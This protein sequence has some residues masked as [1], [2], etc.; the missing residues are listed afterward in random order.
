ML[1]TKF[2]SHKTVEALK[3]LAP[4][5]EDFY[6]A[7]GT[8]LSIYYQHRESL[9]LDFFTQKKLVPDI[10]IGYLKKNGIDLKKIEIEPST[11]HCI[12]NDVRVS[13][14][15][16]NYPVLELREFKGIKIASVLDIASMKLSA[17][18]G[19]SE[20]KDYFDIVEILSHMSFS[21]VVEGFVKKFGR[22]VD[23]YHLVLALE[24]FD[25]VEDSP[26]PRQAKREWN[27]VK[28]FLR[29]NAKEFFDTIK[30]L[31]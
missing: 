31:Q 26:D 23:L 22:E 21:Q 20:K 17:I 29:K 12:L 7:G 27:E 13:F 5:V 16:Y 6:L 19:R 9:D 8:A 15:E 3:T 18:M 1:S 24:Y 10:F 11:I 4:F 25:D 28:E 2:V 14:F 30:S